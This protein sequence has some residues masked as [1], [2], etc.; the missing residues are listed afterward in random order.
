MA[1]IAAAVI[2]AATTAVTIGMQES[3]K[4]KASEAAQQAQSADAS[5]R[6]AEAQNAQS[7]EMA[8]MVASMMNPATVNGDPMMNQYLQEMGYMAPGGPQGQATPGQ[9]NEPPDPSTPR[10]QMKGGGSPSG[11][12]V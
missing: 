12:P 9:P 6:A 10:Q 1:T 5:A 7:E 2:G 4:A 11:M 8:A 3:N